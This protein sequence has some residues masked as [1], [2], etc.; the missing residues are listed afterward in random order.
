MGSLFKTG[1]SGSLSTIQKGYIALLCAPLG[2]INSTVRLAELAH[3]PDGKVPKNMRGQNVNARWLREYL[4]EEIAKG[5]H[6]DYYKVRL[7]GLIGILE[8]LGLFLRASKEDKGTREWVEFSGAALAVTSAAME[9]LAVGTEMVKNRTLVSSVTHKGA[10]VGLGGL[11]LFAGSLASVAGAIGAVL[12][13]MDA[14]K[15]FEKKRL[16]LATALVVRGTAQLSLAVMGAVIGYSFSAPLFEHWARRSAQQGWT[17]FSRGMTAAAQGAQWL[18]N[19]AAKAAVARVAIVIRVAAGVTWVGLAI[20]VLMFIF[21]DDD[22]EDWCQKS[23]FRTKP[24]PDD[25]FDSEGKEME[26]LYLAFQEV[27]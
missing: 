23:V 2:K 4:T 15:A 14:T 26:G 25:G 1:L 5:A 20:T 10:V 22:L 27:R 21:A 9:T 13:F 12:D 7:A 3:A 18:N 19:P 17:G 16:L 11:K 8:G 6:G 24:E